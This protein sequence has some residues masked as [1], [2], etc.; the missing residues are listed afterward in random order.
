[1]HES[2]VFVVRVWPTGRRNK[3]FLASA[4]RVDRDE[5]RT[6]TDPD[7]L[8]RFMTDRDCT[9]PAEQGGPQ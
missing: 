7:E 2:I 5:A 1:M 8:I 6:F 3:G 4:R 9:N